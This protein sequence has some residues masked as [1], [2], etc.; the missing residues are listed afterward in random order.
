VADVPCPHCGGA[1]D[2]EEVVCPTT[3]ADL[4]APAPVTTSAAPT[5]T[6]PPATDAAPE[7]G[8]RGVFDLLKEAAS[9]YR[10]NA[11]ALI[12]LCAVVF[13]PAS[14]V[15]SCAVAFIGRPAAT[16]TATGRS[17]EGLKTDDL[18]ASQRALQE[19]YARRADAKTIERLQ[20]EQT[21]LLAEI[22]RRSMAAASAAMGSFTSFVLDL[23]ARFVTMF[24]V[25][26]VVVPLT[27]GAVTLFLAERAVGRAPPPNWRAVVA[28]G[29]RRL[30]P[31]LAAVFP[32]AALIGF[33]ALF[34][35]LPGFA[36]AIAFAFLAPAILLEGKRGR[37]AFQRSVELVG[38]E[39]L[40]V[41]LLIVI[42]AVLNLLAQVLVGIFVPSSATFTSAVLSDLV[43]T[44]FLPLPMLAL[45]M[46]YFDVRRKRDG[47]ASA[48]AL[49]DR[50]R[51]EL[52][53]LAG[54]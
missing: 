50:L 10:Q 46:L 12:L 18:A 51:A 42:L 34:F 38:A 32:A 5:A 21:R 43:T 23:L 37:V 15:K 44:L 48:A 11:R 52:A 31:L 3:G 53:A 36:L 41:A 6:T 28:L 54:R 40:R 33:A 25:F 17:V 35:G 19:A 30:G 26:G 20:A 16:A 27:N 22:G 1:H 4:R 9:V 45:V 39:W 14:I 29:A 13:V 7:A 24:F 2:A 49:E 8:E 47:L